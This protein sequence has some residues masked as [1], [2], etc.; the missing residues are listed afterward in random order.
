VESSVDQSLSP[1]TWQDSRSN[2]E[3]GN[4]NGSALSDDILG[5]IPSDSFS[6]NCLSDTFSLS[7]IHHFKDRLVLGNFY[8][9]GLSPSIVPLDTKTILE[10][11]DLR[12]GPYGSALGRAYCINSLKSYPEMMYRSDGTLP[13][14][15]N[16]RGAQPAP[17]ENSQSLNNDTTVL[18]EPLAICSSIMRMYTARVRVNLA[19]IWRTIQGEARRIEDQ[20]SDCQCLRSS[21]HV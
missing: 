6:W 10:K 14:L 1:D 18:P 17:R 7:Q 8:V 21:T 11:R 2:R 9:G 16:P 5:L 20:F 15:I 19:F 4:V 13:P 3:T 12:A